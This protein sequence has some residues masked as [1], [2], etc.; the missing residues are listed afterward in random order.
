[1]DGKQRDHQ[2]Q[3][4]EQR[5]AA[6]QDGLNPAR[7]LE[8]R[9]VLEFI[10]C[11]VVAGLAAMAWAARDSMVAVIALGAMLMIFG[12]V[13]IL[14]LLKHHGSTEEKTT[15]VKAQSK[16]QPGREEPPGN[17]LRDD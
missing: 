11:A 8:G 10:F 14:P 2:K 4:L 16:D 9:G 17:T 6:Y 12:L 3:S 15:V 7:L 13:V 1:M 5:Y